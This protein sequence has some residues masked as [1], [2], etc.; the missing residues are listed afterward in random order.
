MLPQRLF[1]APR[2]LCHIGP[3]GKEPV[4]ADPTGAGHV[5]VRIRPALP[6]QIA[7]SEFGHRAAT[8]HW[9]LPSEVPKPRRSRSTRAYP[10]G[11]QKLGSGASHEVYAENETGSGWRMKR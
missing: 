10:R 5:A 6:G 11:T 9:P 8:F 7:A 2:A 1:G 4:F 3:E